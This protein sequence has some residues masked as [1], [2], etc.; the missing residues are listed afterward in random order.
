[1]RKVI[2][3]VTVKLVIEMNKGVEVSEVIQEMDYD[4]TSTVDGTEITD[5]EIL[6][7]EV[8]DSK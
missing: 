7:H 5:M 4:F 3:E 8:T 2:V 1:M 6:E